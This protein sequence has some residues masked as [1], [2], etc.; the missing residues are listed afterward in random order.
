MVAFEPSVAH[1]MDMEMLNS[2]VNNFSAVHF[3]GAR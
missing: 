3:C 2:L 1:V